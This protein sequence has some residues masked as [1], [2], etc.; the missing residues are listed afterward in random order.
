[1]TFRDAAIKILSETKSPLHYTE[2]TEKA[3]HQ[4]LLKTVGKTP[5]NTMN[6]LI[7]K[8]IKTKQNNSIFKRVGAGFFTINYDYIKSKE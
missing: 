6:A 4:N 7:A 8:E 5:H 3:L 2:I 1:M